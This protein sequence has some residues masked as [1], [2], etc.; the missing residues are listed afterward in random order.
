MFS[1]SFAKRLYFISHKRIKLFPSRSRFYASGRVHYCCSSSKYISR[2]MLKFIILVC[3]ALY[4]TTSGI[5][6]THLWCANS[7]VSLEPNGIHIHPNL[8]TV[9]QRYGWTMFTALEMRKLFQTAG[10]YLFLRLNRGQTLN[11]R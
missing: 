9:C 6:M 10:L 5:H 2:A 11:G 8:V 7:S 1:P 3:G 4:A